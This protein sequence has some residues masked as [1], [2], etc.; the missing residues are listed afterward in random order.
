MKSVQ[1][2]SQHLFGF[3]FNNIF[4]MDT[5]INEILF[6]LQL[7]ALKTAYKLNKTPFM[8]IVRTTGLFVW[9]KNILKWEWIEKFNSDKAKINIL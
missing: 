2:S 7:N 6:H 9:G 4:K 8:Q 1:K 3:I 5:I